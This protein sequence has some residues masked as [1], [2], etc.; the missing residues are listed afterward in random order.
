MDPS[1]GT[2]FEFDPE[3]QSFATQ[4]GFVVI[5]PKQIDSEYE[6][7]ILTYSLS[8][9]TQAQLMRQR[10]VSGSSTRGSALIS[11]GSLSATQFDQKLRAEIQSPLNPALR[12]K[13][14]RTEHQNY[15]ENSSHSIFELEGRILELSPDDGIFFSAYGEVT[16]QKREDDVGFAI[17]RRKLHPTSGDGDGEIHHGSETRAFITFADFTRS[18]RN[19]AG[20]R[21]NSD[22]E[23]VVLGFTH[24]RSSATSFSEIFYRRETAFEWNDPAIG[25]TFHYARSV[26]GFLWLRPSS[27]S[28]KEGLSL[29]GQWDRTETGLQTTSTNVFDL[30]HR[31]R[32]RLEARRTRTL[33]KSLMLESGFM[34]T[35]R[36]W[37]DE[38]GS[39]LFHENAVPFLWVQHD[40]GFDLG[41]EVTV[42]GR[43][44]DASMG[45]PTTRTSAIESRLNARYRISF[46]E[47]AELLLA[48][49]LDVDRAEGG[50]FEGGHSQFKMTF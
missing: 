16:R 15:E 47:Q 50:A 19:D 20:D 42:F 40:S 41:A 37:I 29:R 27:N 9:L 25:K 6:S 2:A 8:P 36:E 13:F 22:K 3:Y 11:A 34:W 30:I 35:S 39:V 46:S 45:S 10:F 14:L 12:F 43:Y 18:G 24:R 5:D 49:T 31:S 21:F 28:P 48:L 1:N 26:L 7:D 23:P 17:V 4:S 44:G 33:T 38:N 32:L